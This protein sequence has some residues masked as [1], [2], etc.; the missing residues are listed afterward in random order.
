MLYHEALGW[1]SMT[2]AADLE[3]SFRFRLPS[4]Q[5]CHCAGEMPVT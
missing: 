2:A 3:V 5:Y 1:F 4:K